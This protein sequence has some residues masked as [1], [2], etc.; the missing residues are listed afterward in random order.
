MGFIIF[1]ILCAL[2]IFA[3]IF[4]ARATDSYNKKKAIYD[5]VMEHRRQQQMTLINEQQADSNNEQDTI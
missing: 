4:I 3:G 5:A 2:G 1:L